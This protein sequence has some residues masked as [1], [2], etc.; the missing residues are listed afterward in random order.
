MP[1][2][3]V[4]GSTNTVNLLCRTSLAEGAPVSPVS[5][6]PSWSQY[7]AIAPCLVDITEDVY[8]WAYELNHVPKLATS[9]RVRAAHRYN[10]R[11]VV[12]VVVDDRVDQQNVILPT[13]SCR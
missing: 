3:Y 9:G 12:V 5:N 10:G 6:I 13:R 8:L 4:A 1:M 11:F 2:G 7:L